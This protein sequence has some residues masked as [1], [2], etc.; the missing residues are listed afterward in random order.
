MD[1]LRM[2]WIYVCCFLY[3]EYS[4]AF[5][6]GHVFE[7]SLWVSCVLLFK[8]L[9]NAALL[10]HLVLQAHSK[11]LHVSCVNCPPQLHSP[12]RPQP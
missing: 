4:S 12:V 1:R 2:L 10:D 11:H 8:V 9:C 3:F 5:N 6:L 7:F